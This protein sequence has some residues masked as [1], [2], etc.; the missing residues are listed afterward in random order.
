MKEEIDFVITWVDNTDE[1][2]QKR[3]KEY[4]TLNKNDESN[5]II[6]YR[7]WGTLKY[8]FRAV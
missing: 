1:N 6:R 8:W 3:K 7:D 2:W 4:N 5:S